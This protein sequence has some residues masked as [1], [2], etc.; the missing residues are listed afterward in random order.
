MDNA[1]KHNIRTVSVCLIQYENVFG[2][3]KYKP[4]WKGLSQCQQTYLEAPVSVLVAHRVAG[5]HAS[6][7]MKTLVNLTHVSKFGRIEFR[8]GVQLYNIYLILS[9]YSE[10]Q[11]WNFQYSV[12]IVDYRTHR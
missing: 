10:Q 8:V 1:Q 4:A 11:F 6:L 2:F 7:R 9:M 3:C 5:L 12:I